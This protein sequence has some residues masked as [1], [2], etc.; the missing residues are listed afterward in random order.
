M[1]SYEALCGIDFGFADFVK[2]GTPDEIAE[3][4]AIQSRINGGGPIS[5]QTVRRLKAVP[6]H[7]HLLVAAEMWCSDCRVNVTAM[8]FLCR[9]QP[10]I[11]L[12]IVTKARAEEELRTA[13]GLNDIR[14]PVAAILDEHYRLIGRFIERPSFVAERGVE[15]L[16]QGYRNGN[17]T[18]S[19]LTDILAVLEA[20]AEAAHPLPRNEG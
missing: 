20:A 17:Y 8:D 3:V 9:Q 16:G 2:S 6:G 11:T 4:T 13:L 5:P 10:N 19:T 14:A 18:D 15:A 7:Y 12:T 1:A